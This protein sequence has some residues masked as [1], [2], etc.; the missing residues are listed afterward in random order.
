M[1]LVGTLTDF[2]LVD[3]FQLVALGQKTGTILVR[4]RRAD[5]S[6][7]GRVFFVDG[8]VYG[9]DCAG[10]AGVEAVYALFLASEGDFEFV[11][12]PSADARTIE[13]SNE[14]VIMEAITRQEAWAQ[15]EERVLPVDMP[16][17]LRPRPSDQRD[18]IML[19]PDTWAVI[20]SI[21]GIATIGEIIQRSGLS[22]FRVLPIIA[23]LIDTGLA[24]AQTITAEAGGVI[25]GRFDE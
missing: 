14:A 3:I 13:R 18:Q 24:E 1:A 12:G 2:S 25:Q 21:G 16:I 20:V 9:A 5:Q 10:M 8:D 11:E 19:E 22:R 6:I 23:D 15:V 17:A 7:E 4:G